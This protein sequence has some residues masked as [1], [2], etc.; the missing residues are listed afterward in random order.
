M[1]GLDICHLEE[2]DIDANGEISSMELRFALVQHLFLSPE[3][4]QQ[5][6]S[7]FCRYMGDPIDLQA[8]IDEY[9]RMSLFHV[10]RDITQNWNSID[11][12]HDGK[13]SLNE[14]LPFLEK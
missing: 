4:A 14:L 5:Y 1:Q 3:M 13:I 10:E 2:L 8:F 12:N 6:V 9:L 11:K 7:D